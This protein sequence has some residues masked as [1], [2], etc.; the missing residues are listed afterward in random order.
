[1]TEGPPQVKGFDTVLVLDYG[2]QYGQLIARR[3][4]ECRVY[5]ELIPHDASLDRIRS[6]APKGI[7]LS[8]GP[9]GVYVDD[10]PRV[11]PGLFELGIPVLG[12]CYGAQSLAL[13]LGGTVARTGTSEFG[14]TTLTVHRKGLI[15]ESMRSEEQCWMS[16]RDSITAAP[17][18]FEVLASTPG[19]P[20]AAMEDRERG[21]Y[22]LQFHPEVV[23]TPRGM[24]VLRS[25][26]YKACGCEPTFTPD[27]VVEEAVRGIR[28]QVGDAKA[29]LGLSGGVDSSVAA[30]LMHRAIGDRLTCV[31][32][33]QGMMRMRE[34]E[35]VIETFSGTFGIPLV[36]VDASDR[37][38]ARLHGV[39]DPEQKRKIIGEEFIRCFEEQARK[40]TDA[41]FLVQG[42]L[43][44]DVI[45]SGTR[46]AAKIKSHH[47][48]GGLPE[49]MDLELVEPLRWLFKDEV[50]AVGE[51][52]GLPEHIV[53]R[54]P[55]PGPGLG[56][57]IIGEITRERVD[58]LQR[59]DAIVQD[60]IRKAGL[61][62]ELW[63]CF[64]ILP[65][66]R[67]VGVQGD[68][69]TYGYPIAIR[70]VTSDDAMTADWA[71][72]P[73]DLLE[74][75]ASRIIN[76]VPEVNRVVYDVSS[77]PPSTIEWE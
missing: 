64:A 5:S 54:Q 57:R 20:V 1:M 46:Q 29:I 21:F 30:L 23:H 10:A 70:A 24:D 74:T 68:E 31:F 12:I 37:F 18:G 8:G 39:T 27:A 22:A 33:D 28:A 47:N 35:R 67:S 60:E 62:R 19:A 55:F 9:M 56:I 4:R 51:E 3:V 32:V 61:Y 34:A 16:H 49:K 58:V 69:R 76:E 77:K 15:L 44:S 75:L 13:E 48:V 43:Y 25:F 14:K 45:E 73:Y 50:R 71:K 63:Q 53:W 59:A 7:I 41:K 52:L 6:Y 26:L 66:I 38:L 42:T 36:A 11:D 72:L 65:V 40:L 17:P 2:A